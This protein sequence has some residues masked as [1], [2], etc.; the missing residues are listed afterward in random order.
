VKWKVSSRQARRIRKR[1]VA[2]ARKKRKLAKRG[3]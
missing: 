3:K 2:R 1:A